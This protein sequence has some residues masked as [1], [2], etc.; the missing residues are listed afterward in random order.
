TEA[1]R[2]RA[3]AA[4]AAIRAIERA[5][6]E[7]AAGRD[8]ADLY[9]DAAAR[10]MEVYRHRIEEAVKTGEDRV[11]AQ[12]VGEIERRL[13]LAALR[14]EREEVFRLARD[15]RIGDETARRLVREL[16]LLD[17]RYD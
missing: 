3:A 6:H 14:A 16:D 1:D 10:L 13:R 4:E 8:D 11:L 7:L 9:A 17:A 12:R 5:H 2:A 15:G